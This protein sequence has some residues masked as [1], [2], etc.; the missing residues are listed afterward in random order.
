MGVSFPVL[1][2]YWLCLHPSDLY[3]SSYS[4]VFPSSS[5]PIFSV[6]VLTTTPSCRSSSAT[7]PSFITPTKP[8]GVFPHRSHTVLPTTVD[9]VSNSVCCEFPCSSRVSGKV[10]FAPNHSAFS[11]QATYLR[12]LPN[13]SSSSSAHL[14]HRSKPS[15]SPDSQTIPTHYPRWWQTTVP[16]HRPRWYRSSRYLAHHNTQFAVISFSSSE[17]QYPRNKTPRR[18]APSI[19]PVSSVPTFSF[20]AS[21]IPSFV[22]LPFL[23]FP[24]PRHGKL[25]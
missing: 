25:R 4:P 14:I 8:S 13:P 2:L 9:F 21:L 23:E 20:P 6:Q 18:I 12:P 7:P 11:E 1:S 24:L 5:F 3:R 15:F 10:A 22:H 17:F 19:T 16:K